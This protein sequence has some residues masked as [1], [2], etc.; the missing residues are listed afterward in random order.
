MGGSGHMQREA[1]R[2]TCPPGTVPHAQGT[3]GAAWDLV[4]VGKFPR[5]PQPISQGEVER[6]AP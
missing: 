5:S 2:I 3:P 1:W 6:P 4:G